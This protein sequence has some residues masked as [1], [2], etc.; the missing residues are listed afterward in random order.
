M[1]RAFCAAHVVGFDELR[2]L[3]AT[4]EWDPRTTA[5]SDGDWRPSA[6]FTRAQVSTPVWTNNT[7]RLEAEL[8]GE[9]LL[10]LTDQSFP[11]WKVFVDGEERPLV[12]A[13]AIFRGVALGPGRHDVLFRYQPWTLRAGAFISAAGLAVTLGF[14]LVDLRRGRAA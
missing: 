14:L 5:C 7:V 2:E 3:V 10:V 12:T 9:G 4:G 8:D 1:P 11:G 6:P 13:D